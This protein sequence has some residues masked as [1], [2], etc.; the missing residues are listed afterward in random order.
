MGKRIILS[1]D[2]ACDI[3]EELKKRYDVTFYPYHIILD[4]KEYSDGID[5]HPDDIY[6]AF[7]QKGILPRTAAINVSEYYDYFRQWTDEGYEVIHVS[8]GSALSASFQYCRA[9]A[10]ELEGVYPIDSCSLSSGIGHLVIEAGERIARGMSAADITAEV[11]ALVPKVHAS[12]ILDT[13]EFMRAGG[14]CS[15]V[16]ALG[17]NLLKLKPCIEVDN[18]SGA[19]GVGKI[20]RGSLDKV[21]VQYVEEKLAKYGDSIKKDRAFITHSG[22]SEERIRLV[23]DVVESHDIFGEIHVTRAS[24]TISSHCGPNTLGV[25]FMTK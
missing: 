4:D 6:E 15:A 22:I 10:S 13:L 11:T 1:A 18:S 21:L 17:A 20:Y 19:M 8:L 16:A 3:G 2:S 12:F 7:R 9:A 14:R 5:I 23:R 25:L 24:C